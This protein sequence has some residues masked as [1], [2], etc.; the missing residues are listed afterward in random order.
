MGP[1]VEGLVVPH[2]SRP[3]AHAPV[4]LVVGS[5]RVVEESTG[6]P[7][8]WVLHCFEFFQ[9]VDH[10]FDGLLWLFC[11]HKFEFYFLVVSALR[12]VSSYHVP[13]ILGRLGI[14]KIFHRDGALI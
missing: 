3:G 5:D 1:R 8:R 9:R 4:H 2:E 11:W 7:I 13:Q 12:I 14:V 10:T 6:G